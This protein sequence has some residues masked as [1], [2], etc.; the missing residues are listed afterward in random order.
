MSNYELNLMKM[1]CLCIRLIIANYISLF[2]MPMFTLAVGHI[3]PE[4]L[5]P[6]IGKIVKIG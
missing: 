4:K 6:V 1:K 3:Q 2:I 5:N